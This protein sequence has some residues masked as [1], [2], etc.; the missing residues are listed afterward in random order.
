MYQVIFAG[1]FTDSGHER[2]FRASPADSLLS[3][4][5]NHNVTIPFQCEDGECGSCIVEVEEMGEKSAHHMT[6]K[7][8]DTLIAKG[9]ITREQAEDLVEKDIM[10]QYRLACQCKVW[11][12][13]RVKPYKK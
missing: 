8:L 6:E 13:M 10:C 9:A 2:G 5:K 11:G 7:E 1:E 12:D 3:V 4:A